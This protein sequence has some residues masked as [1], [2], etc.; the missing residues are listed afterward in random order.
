MK[1]LAIDT[2][3]PYLTVI[4][5]NDLASS[6]YFKGDCQTEHSVL[7][8]EAIDECL[9]RTDNSLDELDFIAC[10]TGPGSFTGIRIGV[11]TVKGFLLANKVKVL[12]VTTFEIMA[13]N[14]TDNVDK[15]VLIDAH[16]DNFYVCGFSGDNKV[17]LPPCFM[18]I[19]EI[20]KIKEGYTVISDAQSLP[21]PFRRSD[22]LEG[23]K[24]FIDRNR[25][26]AV[27]DVAKLTPL[28]VKKSQAE[29]Q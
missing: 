3:G 1:Y 11:S 19:G 27:D 4:C 17:I 9:S 2:S 25:N 13:Y 12:P 10:V 20:T 26:N 18:N 6:E 7:L 29:E 22:P 24:R 28:Y 16:H 5:K 23:Y 14:I 21:F 15:L 8:M